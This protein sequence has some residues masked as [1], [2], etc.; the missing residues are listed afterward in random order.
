[1]KNK[2]LADTLSELL[3][4]IGFK[5]KGNF[6][7]ING[8]ILTKMVNIQ[9]SQFS[10]SFY[11]NYGYIIKSI[12]LE[13]LIMHV[14]N[15]FGS[16][17]VNENTRIKELLNLENIIPNEDRKR[18]LKQFIL[19]KLVSKIQAI[20]TEGDLLNELKRRPHLNDIPLTVK[21]YFNLM[22]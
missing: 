17:D 14:F 1:M 9:K 4:P 19:D 7:V 10:N 20:N 5:K 21:K 6:W 15:G 12:P 3:I 8:D 16:I 22:D 2:E 13:D 18:E 11:I